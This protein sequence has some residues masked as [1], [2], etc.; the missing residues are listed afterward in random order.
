[1][2][3][4]VSQAA[5]PQ[6]FAGVS[7]VSMEAGA[8]ISTYCLLG[9]L[10]RPEKGGPGGSG[11]YPLSGISSRDAHTRKFRPEIE[12]NGLNR[13]P[14]R[15]GGRSPGPNLGLILGSGRAIS[16]IWPNFTKTGGLATLAGGVPTRGVWR[17]LG[18]PNLGK[19]AE[20]RENAQ[21]TPLQG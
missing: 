5:T 2:S 10:R 19:L 9:P 15:V 18:P 8:P 20:N 4:L 17:A 1:M 3:A 13:D 21:I 11:G 16:P 14:G 7:K 12:K 6:R